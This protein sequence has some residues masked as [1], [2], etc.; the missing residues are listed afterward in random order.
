MVIRWAAPGHLPLLLPLVESFYAEDGHT[1]DVL[2]VRRALRPL[3]QD[4]R[5]GV[6]YLIETMGQISGYAVVTW[7][8]S[9]KRSG[10]DALLDEIFV[11]E[12]TSGLGGRAIEEIA[13][14]L[15][16][17][18]IPRIHLETEASNHRARAFYRDHGFESDDSIW[19]SRPL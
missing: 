19:M 6:V 17:R 16:A 13:D 2:S 14:D 8:W 3:L 12:P 1:L 5:F 10:R 15:K 9:V 18:S 4:D 11:E 7:E